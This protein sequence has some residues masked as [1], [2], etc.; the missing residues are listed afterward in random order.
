MFAFLFAGCTLLPSLQAELDDE[1]PLV[2]DPV[3]DD[4][5]DC[6][7]TVEPGSLGAL[8]DAYGGGGACWEDEA[9]A[10]ACASACAS[11]LAQLVLAFPEEEAC[12]GTAPPEVEWPFE[13]GTW[14]ARIDR[15]GADPCDLMDEE[16]EDQVGA[17]L[18]QDGIRI[19][20][21]DADHP[22][23]TMSFPALEMDCALDGARYDCTGEGFGG[24]SQLSG[25]FERPTAS[26]ADWTIIDA[27]G[28]RV[29]L[30]LELEA[31]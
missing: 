21:E 2:A 31:R 24:E 26:R 14:D 20:A 27:D 15:V 10:E 7:S 28:C 29:E 3:C 17:L 9:T 23:F 13:A 18:A 30:V 22:W 5:L 12:G 4:Y 6:V 16:M 19:E 25:T 8:V 11:G 1:A